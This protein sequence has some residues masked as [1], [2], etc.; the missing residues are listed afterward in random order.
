M[1][2]DGVY[3]RKLISYNVEADERAHA[4]LGVPLGLKAPA[5]G[6]VAL[7]GTTAQGK[8][9]TAAL[10]G[11]PDKA[12]LDHLCRRG[13]V[14]IAPDH[15]VAGHR[16]AARDVRDGPLLPETSRLD[17]GRQVHLRAFHRHRRLESLPEVD[18]RNIGTLGHSLGGHGAYFLAAYDAASRPRPVIAARR[19]SAITRRWRT[20]PAIA[21]MST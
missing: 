21:G 4:Y 11:M 17:G 18:R 10:S 1:A 7:H 14:V 6:I 9:Q 16:I 20:G 15:F 8:E 12:F 13:F 19:S 2:V 3:T 5:P